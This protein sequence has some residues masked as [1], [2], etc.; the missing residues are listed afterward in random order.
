MKITF[1]LKKSA[2]GDLEHLSIVFHSAYPLGITGGIP[3]FLRNFA[4]AVTNSSL[5]HTSNLDQF[6][7]WLHHSS[8]QDSP[9][10]SW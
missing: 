8:M 4:V 7:S 9:L 1:G 5:S 10:S 6:S 2:P 3:P